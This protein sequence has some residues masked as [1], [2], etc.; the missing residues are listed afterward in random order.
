M[1]S[2]AAISKLPS[3]LKEL[4]LSAVK[5]DDGQAFGTS[6]KE[7]AEV[8][9]W[10]EKVAAGDVAKAETLKVKDMAGLSSN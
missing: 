4:V 5:A 6:E 2:Q 7:K 10:I 3:P 9:D 1:T 8:A